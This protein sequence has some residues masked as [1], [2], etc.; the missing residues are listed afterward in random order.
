M[1]KLF[2]F[3]LILIA[4]FS[5][6]MPLGHADDSCDSGPAEDPQCE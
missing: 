6:M 5:V 4:A 2:F 3:T 1:K